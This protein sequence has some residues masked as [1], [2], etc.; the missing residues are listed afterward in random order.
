MFSRVTLVTGWKSRGSARFYLLIQS[1]IHLAAV[2][3][4]CANG[5]RW[6][7]PLCGTLSFIA[8]D[9]MTETPSSL[10]RSIPRRSHEDCDNRERWMQQCARTRAKR[11]RWEPISP[12]CRRDGEKWKC[13]PSYWRSWDE[14]KKLVAQL[15]RNHI[16]EWNVTFFKSECCFGCRNKLGTWICNF[17]CVGCTYQLKKSTPTLWNSVWII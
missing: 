6:P 16:R 10:A 2:R 4:L 12:L 14:A 1:L 3:S 17:N 13:T 11:A 9:C 8:P 15:D 5:L 7:L